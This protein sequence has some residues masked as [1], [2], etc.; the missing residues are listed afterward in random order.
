MLSKLDSFF[1]GFVPQIEDARPE[2]RRRAELIVAFSFLGLIFG[3]IFSI[4]YLLIG[5]YWGVGIILV[6]SALF[7][8]VPYL[9]RKGMDTN[10]AGNY[11][12]AILLAG[13]FSLAI[14]EGGIH[15]HAVAWLVTA[16]MVAHLLISGRGAYISA[17]LAFLAVI[18]LGAV[19]YLG[20]APA[21]T[22]A[23]KW[24]AAVS[25]AGYSTLAVFLFALGLIFQSGLRD[26]Q[27]RTDET[28]RALADANNRLTRLNEEKSEF[29]GIAAHDLKN[30]L[31]AVLQCTEAL[32][33]HE[34][35]RER[36]DRAIAAIHKETKR[37]RRL[38]SD[39]LDLHAIEEGRVAL[40]NSAVNL[41]E[42]LEDIVDNAQAEAAR[43][44]LTLRVDIE[45][46]SGAQADEK[47]VA[48]I[49]E[50]LLSNAIKFSKTG[51]IT[52]AI[53][54]EGNNAIIAISDQGPGISADDQQRL[55]K[56]FSRLTARPT[57]GESSHGLGLSI[58]K[59][60]VDAL[61]GDIQCDSSLGSGTTFTVR[62]PKASR[63]V[64]PKLTRAEME[65]AVALP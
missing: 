3:L 32:S 64:S 42:A 51:Q 31:A 2:L 10:R 4:F 57:A 24:D 36:A 27:R 28:L 38:V 39:L 14:V 61:A 5:H 30:P 20:Y 17:V 33:T 47:A 35:P 60:L 41:A 1:A 16:P 9:L 21:I 12:C 18:F 13:F 50:N 8:C 56:R 46:G 43:K 26:A 7:S 63:D 6:C 52:V 11:Y 58:V 62:L 25:I 49:V 23:P 40:D 54:E 15:R 34:L 44:N 59:R 37:M 55:F 19:E 48:Q 53:R 29:L 22:Y 45:P 65:R